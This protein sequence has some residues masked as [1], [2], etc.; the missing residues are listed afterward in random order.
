[1]Y[2][3]ALRIG[4][5]GGRSCLPPHDP[6]VEQFAKRVYHYMKGGSLSLAGSD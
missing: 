6:L 3:F 1:M 5:S 2:R 4:Y